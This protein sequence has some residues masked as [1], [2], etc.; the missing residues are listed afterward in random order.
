MHVRISRSLPMLLMLHEVRLSC[1]LYAK[2][3]V[4]EAVPTDFIRRRLT[5]QV[6]SRC[7]LKLILLRAL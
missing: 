5:G 6:R 3:V 1:M 4:A 2:V 7:G